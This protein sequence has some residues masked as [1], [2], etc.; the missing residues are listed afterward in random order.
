M[1]TD[2]IAS[3]LDTVTL[4]RYATMHMVEDCSSTIASFQPSR[5]CKSQR[6]IES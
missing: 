4:N 1:R 2:G 3:W 5:A 6:Y